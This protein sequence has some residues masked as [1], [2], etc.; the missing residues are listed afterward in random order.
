MRIAFQRALSRACMK[1]K[2]V[3]LITGDLGYSAFEPLRDQFPKQFLNAGVAEQN[4][5]GVAAGMALSGK[6]VFA[7]SIATF[8]SMRGFEQIRDDIAYQNLPVRIVG[9]GG[10]F[11]YGYLGVTHYAMED[12]AIMRALPNMAVV[13]PVDPNETEAVIEYA[14]TYPG[15]M[16]IRL[17][18]AGEKNV[19][20]NVPRFALGK[21][22]VLAK[23]GDIAIFVAGPLVQNTLEAADILAAKKISCKVIG[24]SSIKPIDK[25]MIKKI[26]GE[27]QLLVSLEEHNVIGGLGSAISDVL[28]ES[29]SR[30]ALMKLGVPDTFPKCIGT[31]DYLRDLYGLSPAKIADSISR[32]IKKNKS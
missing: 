29:G 12:M 5:I 2:N 26:S 32:F 25:E 14:I 4:M 28:T 6:T 7:Y 24:A 3:V 18:K 20:K 1:N 21:F 9:V 27:C 15:P 13:A 31:Q 30:S 8:A 23:E 10:G 17:G 22:S 19:F 11:S 16:Y